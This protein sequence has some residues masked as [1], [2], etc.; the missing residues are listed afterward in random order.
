MDLRLLWN[1]HA[2]KKLG[3]V[4]TKTDGVKN[5]ADL[6]TK[7]PSG[8]YQEKLC[9]M[10]DLVA[11]DDYVTPLG[12]RVRSISTDARMHGAGTLEGDKMLLQALLDMNKTIIYIR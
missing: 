2:V 7:K 5:G 8:P 10:S 3:L 4:I 6:G 12:V 9:S 1:Q 11:F